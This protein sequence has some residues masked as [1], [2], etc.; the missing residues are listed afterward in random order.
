MF[1]A[2]VSDPDHAAKAVRTAL[3]IDRALAEAAEAGTVTT[4]DGGPVETRIG[5]N[6]GT[7][8][9]GNVGAERRY[10]YTV[11]GDAVNLAAR[12]E[13]GAKQFGVRL[14]AGEDTVAAAGA[15]FLWREIDRVRVVG[16]DAPVTLY[17]PLGEADAVSDAVRTRKDRYEAA[18]ARLRAGEVDA[19]VAAFEALAADGDPAAAKTAER[20]RTLRAHILAGDWDGVTAL[21]SK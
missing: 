12:L 1:G 15:G 5:L 4:P 6:T 17:E 16:R 9:V 20:A 11:M 10:A 14:L 7:M 13:S 19:A 8:T 3:A 18:L 21:T 2:P